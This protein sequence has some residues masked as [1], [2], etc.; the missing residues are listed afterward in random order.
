MIDFHSHVLPKLDDG[1]KN[2]ETSIKMLE[3]SKKQGVTTVVC[4]PHYYGRKHSPERFLEKRREARAQLEGKIP[5][6]MQ[7]RCGAEVYFTQDN[8]VAYEDLSMLCIEGTRYIMLEMPFTPKFSPRLFEKIEALIYETD[9][10]PIIV[11]VDRYPAVLKNPSI[12]KRFLEMG[13]LLQ[14]NA[15]AF[16]MKGIKSF[17]LALLKKGLIHALGT[18][19][20]NLEDRAPNLSTVQQVLSTVPTSIRERLEAT[21]NAILSNERIVPE[22]KA[23][24]KFFGKYF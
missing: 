5:E 13:C 16:E 24:R 11:H 8:V 12:V 1:A 22:V 2:V 4:T 10:I 9:C 17:A 21:Q 19:M 18:D 7:L 14:V 3:E 20:H 15:E 6:G 23:V